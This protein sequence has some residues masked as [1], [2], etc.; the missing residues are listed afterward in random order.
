MNDLPPYYFRV[1]D[2][3]AAVFRLDVEIG[4]AHV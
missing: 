3:G 2:N 1:R 4:R